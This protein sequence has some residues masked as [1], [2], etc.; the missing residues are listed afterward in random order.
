MEK[1]VTTI[2][3]S[4]FACILKRGLEKFVQK[5][6]LNISNGIKVSLKLVVEL[7]S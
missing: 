6:S 3:E 4:R 5:F 1:R 7:D 2:I